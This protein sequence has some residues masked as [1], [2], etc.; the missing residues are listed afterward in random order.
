MGNET[1]QIYYKERK[2]SI[3]SEG[4]YKGADYII[5]SKQG[6]FPV[7]YVENIIGAN[8]LYDDVLN[9]IEVH[10][11]FTFHGQ[12]PHV[13]NK[14]FYLGW[15]YAHADDYIDMKDASEELKKWTFDEIYTQTIHVIDQMKMYNDSKVIK[16]EVYYESLES[17]GI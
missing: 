11:G 9:N 4:K 1:K 7:V 14:A 2:D 5:I 3:I 6:R 13:N 15:D 10:G 17:M 8:G 12:L 16:S